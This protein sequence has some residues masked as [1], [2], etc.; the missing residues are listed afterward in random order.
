[1]TG[2]GSA[3]SGGTI[4]A[5]TNAGIALSSTN[6]ASFSWMNVTNGG[7]DGVRA[8]SVN[9][10]SLSNMSVSGNG[11]AAGESGLD[12]GGGINGTVTIASSTFTGSFESNANFFTTS[13]SVNIGVTGSTFSNTS[14]A[15]A[16]GIHV[17][18]DNGANATVSVT[19]STFSHNH[20]D[21]F[22][23]AT[24]ASATGTNSVTFSNNTASDD[25]GT[26]YGGTDLGGGVQIDPDASATT[27]YT[28]SGNTITGAV[29]HSILIDM[30]ASSTVSGVVSGTISGNTIGSAATVDS[31][32]SQGDAIDIIT[33]GAGNNRATITN[34]TLREWANL[35]AILV[36]GRNGT[37]T[38]DVKIQ[39]NNMANPGTFAG[40]ALFLQAGAGSTDNTTMCADVGGA[41]ALAN[42]MTGA[43]ANGSTDFRLR[44]VG[45]SSTIRLPGYGGGS[46]D[47]TAVINFIKANNG[48]T[49]TGSVASTTGGFP[50]GAA[51]NT[52]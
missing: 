33:D 49:P 18:S 19:G 12:A 34:N 3:G 41:G 23:F 6:S 39:G 4:T 43:G 36:R 7:D 31:G 25:R 37:N 24:N 45:P 52:P 10:L 27:T 5:S 13:G 15:G 32:T 1:V 30:G 46:T 35:S 11:N 9:G 26:T 51:C 8:S 29:D 38:T 50:G 21:S 44:E 40:N 48:G 17:N 47:T 16:D 22:Q 14:I 20:G 2:T 42:S 28:I